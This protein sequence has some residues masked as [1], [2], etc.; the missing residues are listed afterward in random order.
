MLRRPSPP[1]P[2]PPRPLVR[3]L[4]FLLALGFAGLSVAVV[5]HVTEASQTYAATSTSA[6]IVDLA[7]GLGLVVAGV[8]Y[9]LVRQR[10][11]VGLLA[12]MIGVAWLSVDWIGWA[13]GPAIVRSVAMV[14]APF[15]LPF[16]VHLSVAFPTGR[17]GPARSFARRRRL[18]RDGIRE[19]GVGAVAGP[20]PRPLLLVQ[21]HGQLIPRACRARLGAIAH[22]ALAVFLARRR[23]GARHLMCRA[24]QP[25][26]AR[27]TPDARTLPRSGSPC[28]AAT[29]V[30]HA[31]LLLADPAENPDRGV[32][33][34][35]FFARAA[36]LVALAAGITWAVLRG[37]RTRRSVARLADE[38]G[39]APAPGSLRAVAR[40][41][42]RR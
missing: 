41:V 22:D 9:G 42:A 3:W 13:D 29:Q 31:G 36:V 33:A 28:G 16:V 1:R 19:P 37:L 24:A 8:A 35:V 5:A 15:L 23:S 2:R 39:A 10:R 34:A 26:I 21:L 30:L 7:P 17:V 40:P 32:F 20:V 4:P 6:A 38:L 12:A 27:R 25:G 18:R 11:S 14:V